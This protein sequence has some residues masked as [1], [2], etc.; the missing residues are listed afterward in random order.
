[1]S[2]GKGGPGDYH[3]GV[4][5][6]IASQVFTGFSWISETNFKFDE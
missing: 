1:M 3:E 5:A 4:E 2:L 6:L